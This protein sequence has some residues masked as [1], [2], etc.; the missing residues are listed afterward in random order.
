MGINEDIVALRNK[1]VEAVSVGF[2]EE[3]NKA[4]YEF[5]LLQIM[6][7]SDKHRLNCI[8]RADTLKMQA[9]TAEG[10]AAAFS[11]IS[12]I[13]N[14][15]VGSMINRSVRDIQEEKDMA[16]QEAEALLDKAEA[17][18]EAVKKKTTHKKRATKKKST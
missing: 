14:S 15:I 1:M 17:K 16:E 5:T 11:M 12:S 4:T 13:V 18:A 2:I 10:Q 7:E 3:K 9:A 6:K 8:K